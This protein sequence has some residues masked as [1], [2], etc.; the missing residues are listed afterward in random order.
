M[1]LVDFITLISDVKLNRFICDLP[2]SIRTI[3]KDED[4]DETDRSNN[5][6]KRKQPERSQSR[7]VTNEDIEQEWK[8]RVSSVK[9]REQ[10]VRRS[11]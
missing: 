1:N 6:K 8:K 3:A 4:I 10:L 5:K 11:E 9:K 2:S 7:I